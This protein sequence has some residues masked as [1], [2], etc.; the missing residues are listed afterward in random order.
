M[1]TPPP[2]W[3]ADPQDV[4][5]LRWWDGT[6]W[7]EHTHPVPG[8]AQQLRPDLPGSWRGLSVAVQL[9]LVGSFAAAVFNYWVDLQVLAFDEE[10]RLR[11]DSLTSADFARIDRLLQVTTVGLMTMLVSGVL[12]IIWLHTAHRSAR[13]DRAVLR[14]SSGW[15][16]G[17]WFVPV[18]NFWRPFQ[19]VTDVRRGATG[20]PGV[21]VPLTQGWWWGLFVGMYALSWLAQTRAV[22]SGAPP[23]DSAMGYSPLMVAV[24]ETHQWV[25]LTTAAAAVLAI[26]VV[27]DLTRVVLAPPRARD[28]G[29]S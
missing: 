17:G 14:H 4:N 5:R 15:A 3:F 1:T 2:A 6:R 23:G 25:A 12:F 22:L 28:H 29:R 26:V 24:A 13:M 20:D 21:R 8:P 10:V 11:P 7:T 18:L 19:M 9:A 27:R 16:I